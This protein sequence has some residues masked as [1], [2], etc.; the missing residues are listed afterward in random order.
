MVTKMTF[1]LTEVKSFGGS[2]G[3]FESIV[4]FSALG[5]ISMLSLVDCVSTVEDSRF[6]SVFAEV[7]LVVKPLLTLELL[8]D[9]GSGVMNLV[10]KMLA[11]VTKVAGVSTRP[12]VEDVNLGE[13]S[14]CEELS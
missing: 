1:P 5:V 3:G 14:A 4:G 8:V 11:S 9:C 2:F 6:A 12:A 13:E 7:K 10:T